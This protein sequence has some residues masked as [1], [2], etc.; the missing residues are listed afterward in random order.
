[1]H[2]V[3]ITYMPRPDATPWAEKNALCV[4]YRFVLERKKGVEPDGHHNT[5]IVGTQEGGR[6]VKRDESITLPRNDETTKGR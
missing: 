1:M 4:A 5:A 6:G 3:R 2:G